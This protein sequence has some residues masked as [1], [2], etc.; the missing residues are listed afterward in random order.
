MGWDKLFVVVPAHVKRSDNML[1]EL[2][3]VGTC[4]LGFRSLSAGFT[5][6][7]YGPALCAW[8]GSLLKLSSE[9]LGLMRRG[10]SKLLE[11]ICRL[12]GEP[13][14]KTAEQLTQVRALLL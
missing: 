11:H 6:R 3:E 12:S 14:M 9:W 1:A 10:H 2:F 5:H 8:V 13:C 4:V 7:P